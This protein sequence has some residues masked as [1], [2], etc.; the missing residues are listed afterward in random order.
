[1]RSKPLFRPFSADELRF[2]AEAKQGQYD[3]AAREVIVD[4]ETNGDKVFSLM[5]GWAFRYKALPNGERQ[6]LDFVLAGDLIGLQA[7]ML[8]RLKHGVV[9]LTE[10]TVCEIGSSAVQHLFEVQP[11]LGAALMQTLLIDHER[12][13]RRLLLLGRQRPTQRLTYLLLEL[14][15]RMEL[16]DGVRGDRCALP[17]TYAHLADALGLS[18]AQLARSLSELR[19]RS[20]ARL[21]G[22][23]LQLLE[24]E[25]MA[26]YCAYDGSSER[27][28]RALI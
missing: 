26:H 17:L 28:Q 13:D 21:Q 6:I 12:A 4:T 16:R 20:W 5:A 18:R 2:V 9:A 24:R 11:A 14:F 7:P 19:D 3:V 22:G 27:Q 15:E 10:A 8:G 1:V 25:E 23:E